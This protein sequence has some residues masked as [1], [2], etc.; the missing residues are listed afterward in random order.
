M[1]KEKPRFLAMVLLGTLLVSGSALAQRSP[2]GNGVG[3][4]VGGGGVPSRIGNHYDHKAYQPSEADI[5]GAERRPGVDC[6]SPAG[7]KAD[8]EL[9]AIRRDLDQLNRDYPPQPSPPT[10]WKR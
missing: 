6:S 10:E 9:Q 7:T 4:S 2:L 5:C 3:G 1:A 8:D